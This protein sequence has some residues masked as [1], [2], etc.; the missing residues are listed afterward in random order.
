MIGKMRT[1]HNPG[2]IDEQIKIDEN[3][4]KWG[5][6]RI[7]ITVPLGLKVTHARKYF[8]IRVEKDGLETYAN[9]DA[10]LEIQPTPP[11]VIDTSPLDGARS[12]SIMAQITATFSKP[13]NRATIND[14]TFTLIYRDNVNLP[15]HVTGDIILSSD[16]KTATF[17]PYIS[18]SWKEIHS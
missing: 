1:S 10:E 3:S 18:S 5:D 14:S 4:V 12:V 11:S 15:V 7:D 2:S 16:G 17:V 8:V 9:S 13:V 6:N